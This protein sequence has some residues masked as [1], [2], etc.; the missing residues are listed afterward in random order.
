M[1]GR[2]EARIKA[3]TIDDLFFEQALILPVAWEG[4]SCHHSPRGEPSALGGGEPETIPLG[5]SAMEGGLGRQCC[6][7]LPDA[8]V[9][10]TDETVSP[11]IELMSSIREAACVL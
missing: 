1:S 3:Q 2:F 4:L 7:S 6:P 5:L 8:M 9:G 10:Q 11:A